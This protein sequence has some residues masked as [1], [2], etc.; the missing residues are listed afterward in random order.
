MATA[1]MYAIDILSTN[2]AGH[3]PAVIRTIKLEANDVASVA[4]KIREIMLRMPGWAP[5]DAGFRV[6]EHDQIVRT[7]ILPGNKGRTITSSF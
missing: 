1:M 2:S 6:R 7:R 5:K 3:E 4:K